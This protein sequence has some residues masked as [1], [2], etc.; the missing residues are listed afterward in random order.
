M[1]AMIFKTAPP[2]VERQQRADKLLQHFGLVVCRDAPIGHPEGKKGISGGQKR[3]LSV[4]LELC[5][6][7]C[8]ST[9]TSPPRARRP[10]RAHS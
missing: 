7:R 9:S 1:E 10:H 6:S 3:R 2:L 8:C 4:A 5:G